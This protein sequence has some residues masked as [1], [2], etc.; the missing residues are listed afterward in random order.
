MNRLSSPEKVRVGTGIRRNYQWAGGRILL[1][2][3]EKKRKS[4]AD[5]LLS[6]EAEI[7][8]L[9]ADGFIFPNELKVRPRVA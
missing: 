7:L 1:L 4:G 5:K 8:E 6:S 3:Q 9:F 2:S